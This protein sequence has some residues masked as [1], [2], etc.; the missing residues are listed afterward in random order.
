MIQTQVP[1]EGPENLPIGIWLWIDNCE[2]D[3]CRLESFGL[4]SWCIK[5]FEELILCE[6][7]SVGIEF[8]KGTCSSEKSFPVVLE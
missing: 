6:Y 5:L 7:R 8:G 2:Y 3:V 1:R 4:I